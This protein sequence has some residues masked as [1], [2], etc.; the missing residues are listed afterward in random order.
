MD[1]FWTAYAR[2][3]L[4]VNWYRKRGAEL[5]VGISTIY[6]VVRELRGVRE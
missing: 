3:A 4:C 6:R 2:R 1:Q 5:G